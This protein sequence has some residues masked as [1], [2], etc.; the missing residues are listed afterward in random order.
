L[1]VA[2]IISRSAAWR[3][4]AA[5]LVAQTAVSTAEQGI[6]TLAGFIKA[7]LG[8]SGAVVGLVVGAMPLGRVLGAYFGGVAVDRIGERVVLTTASLGVAAAV[9]LAGLAPLGPMLVLLCL[10]GVLASTVTPAGGK[11][12]LLSFPPSARA[13]AMGIRQ[14]GIPLGGLT[15][16]AILPWAARDLGWESAL[17]V[18]GVI[19]AAGALAAALVTPRRAPVARLAP[20]AAPRETWRALSRHPE[21]RSVVLWGSLVVGAQFTLVAFLA[22][23]LADSGASTLTRAALLVA[24]A[25]AGGVAGRIGWGVLS[26]RALSG[27]RAPILLGLPLLGVAA[28]LA[29]V[30]LPR[31]AGFGVF[32]LVAAAAGAS[33]IGWQGIWVTLLAELAGPDLAGSATGFGLTFSNIAA[34]ATPPLFGLTADL[35]GYRVGWAALAAVVA[36]AVIPALRLRGGATVGSPS[37]EEHAP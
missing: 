25:Q 9:I 30:V 21:V 18:A 10:G 19:V 12:V 33:L 1:P 8:V 15:A 11:L 36:L 27:R 37:R 24:I 17:V 4:L 29:L 6:P 28:L 34:V 5:A 14:T 7:G 32:A 26:D 20:A 22:A 16:A 3:T 2:A 35:A 31:G 23:D 13:I